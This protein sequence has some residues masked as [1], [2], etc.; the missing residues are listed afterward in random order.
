LREGKKVAEKL[1]EIFLDEKNSDGTK[2]QL[3]FEFVKG[4]NL[5]PFQTRLR[6][7]DCC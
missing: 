4:R 2:K 6:M 1:V 7:N 5:G 3:V